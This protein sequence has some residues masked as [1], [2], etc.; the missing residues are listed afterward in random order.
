MRVASEKSAEKTARIAGTVS[1]LNLFGVPIRLHFTF[2]LLLVF[3]VFIGVG[4]KQSGPQTAIYVGAIFFSVMLHEV[5]HA[6][7]ARRFGI[8]TL[9][10]IM[11]PIGGVSRLERLPK[12]FQELW[13]ALAGPALNLALGVGLLASQHNF[14]P[15]ATL[16]EPTDANLVERIAVGNLLIGLFNLLPAYPMDGGRILRA[17]VSLYRPEEVATQVAASTGKMLAVGM[18][19]FGLL[20]S[21]FFLV[22]I[23]LFVYLGAMQEGAAARGKILTSGR[24]VR[25]AMIT[26]FRA[27]PHGSTVRDAGDLLLATSQH[28]FPV[29]LGNQVLGL[30]S[31]AALMRALLRDGP[32]AYVSGA[33]DREFPRLSPE[34]DLSDAM[35]KVAELR[36][37]AL[38]MDDEDKLVGMLTP[39][40]LSEYIL[41]KHMTAIQSRSQGR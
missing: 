20:S 22:F 6:L 2:L 26:D 37:P 41:L 32:E 8:R 9:E 27:L 15:L 31:R 35:Q 38:V 16:R 34:M 5:A 3:L 39:E 23:S 30:L 29:M 36:G 17:I 33:M 25:E 1:F 18:L 28:D 13:V 12:A 24:Q 4:E 10:I 19:L 11:F 40:H 21:N 14:I 7:V